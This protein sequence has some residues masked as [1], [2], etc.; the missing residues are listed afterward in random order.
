VELEVIKLF[1]KGSLN[2]VIPDAK[3]IRNPEFIEAGFRVHPA[4]APE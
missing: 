2:D 3:A 1:R 4:D